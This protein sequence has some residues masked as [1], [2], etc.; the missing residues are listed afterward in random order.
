VPLVTCELEGRTLAVVNVNALEDVPV[1]LDRAPAS[2]ASEDVSAR[3][4]RRAR[5][6]IATVRIPPPPPPA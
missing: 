2:F 3:L 5:N 1:P 4:A 6:W